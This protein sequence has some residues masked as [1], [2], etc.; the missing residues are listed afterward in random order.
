M[1]TQLICASHSPLLYCYAKE[2]QDW[3]GLQQAFADRAKAIEAFD[4]ELIIA[5]GSDHFNGFFLKT[6]PA[7]C[8][9]LKAEGAGDI[10]GF[11]GP[12]NVPEDLATACVESLRDQDVDASV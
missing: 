2:P 8:V 10:G 11:A 9:G 6:M 4:P 1:S 3:E 5:F 7:F 12:V